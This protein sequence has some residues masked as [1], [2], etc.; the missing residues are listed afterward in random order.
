M[1]RGGSFGGGGSSSPGGNNTE[2][3]YN[4]NG[5][6]GGDA[7]FTYDAATDTATISNV[8][9]S[10]T[11]KVGTK[12][13]TL[14][15]TMTLN[16][17]SD[18]STLNIGS[19]GTLASGAFAATV[20]PSGSNTQVQFNS[21]G[22]FGASSN[23]TFSGTTLNIAGIEI[24]PTSGAYCTAVG[25]SALTGATGTQNTALGYNAAYNISS[26]AGDG[27]NTVVGASS[28]YNGF[29]DSCTILGQGSNSQG[30]GNVS[31]GRITTRASSASSLRNTAV[32][33]YCFYDLTSGALNTA[34]GYGAG[35]TGLT[36]GSNN[37]FIGGLQYGVGATT[38]GSI[39]IGNNNNSIGTHTNALY[40]FDGAG[41]TKL[42]QDSSN[43]LALGTTTTTYDVTFLGASA[44]T[45]GML[46]HSTANTAGNNLT[47]NA[48][49]ATSSA[50]DKNGGELILQS[51]QSTGAGNSG[52]QFQVQKSGSTGTAD[53]S[54][55]TAAK[56]TNTGDLCLPNASGNGIRVNTATPTFP[57]HDLIGT[58]IPDIAGADAPT[59]A[60]FRG[61][62]ARAYAFAANDRSDYFYHIPHDYLPNQTAYIH[63][64]WGHNGTNISGT[65]TATLYVTYSKGHNQSTFSAE[66]TTT[67]TRSSLT[68]GAYPQYCHDVVEV[69]LTSA[70]GSAST[71]DSALIEPDGVI[72]VGLILTT[73]PTITGGT[74]D[75]FI[76][77]VDIHY[78]SI[79]VGTKNKSPNFYT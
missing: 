58:F 42:Y 68:I 12:Q 63:V 23:L 20:A 71:L 61:G 52:I 4:N 72:L 55:T 25:N 50:T 54:Y 40:I 47:I 67:C 21:S 33:S 74:A 44:K 46:R 31:V 78:Q 41:S 51:G 34:I 29:Y 24:K 26:T 60:A 22:S 5:S 48:G 45:L 13:L 27:Y 64:H 19:G 3:Q 37:I 59:I 14:S 1:I 17:T 73:A 30:T 43:K 49:G 65:F 36:T 57:Y 9:A 32:G 66:V 39:F 7:G 8:I 69:A 16:A 10:S 76:F 11:L 79:G 38:S 6:L 53:N 35:C 75:P 2:V 77:T 62:N 15:K 70:G 18:G 56:I 28:A